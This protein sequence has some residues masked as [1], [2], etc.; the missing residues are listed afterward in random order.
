MKR[1]LIL[2]VNG[3]DGSYLAEL[4][5]DKGYDVIGW[6]PA[7]IPVTFDN[8]TSI[9]ERITL[10][11][12]DITNK[13]SIFECIHTYRPNEVFNLASPSSPTAS[14]EAVESVGD[15]TG[16]GVARLLEAIRL[17]IPTARFYQASSSEIFG[18]PLESPQ[19]ETTPFRPTTPYGVAKLY[20]HWLTTIYRQHYKLYSVSGIL[21]NHESPRRGENFV[22]RKITRGAAQIKLGMANQ[23]VLGNLHASRDWGYAPDYVRAMWLMLQQDQPDD[24]VIGTGCTHTVQ[25]LCECAFGYLDLDYKDYVVQDKRFYLVEDGKMR[26]ADCK[27]AR[28]ILHWEPR[29]T[30]EQLVIEMVEDDIKQLQTSSVDMP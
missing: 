18:N 12:G 2:G 25:Q 27:H 16:L 23:L 10:I 19:D 4:L 17:E 30:F 21:Y 29:V 14:W 26:I 11:K 22:S 13:D 8:I 1:A 3:Q 9:R 24:F 28:E 20:A 7:N 5:L 15:I 6:I